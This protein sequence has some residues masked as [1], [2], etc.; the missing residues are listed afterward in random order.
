MYTLT[1]ISEH[2]IKKKKYT[3]HNTNKFNLFTM[4]LLRLTQIKKFEIT[5]LFVCYN[6]TNI[7]YNIQILFYQFL[8]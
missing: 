7:L 6:T 8:C 5:L 1:N 3:H 2:I 4:V